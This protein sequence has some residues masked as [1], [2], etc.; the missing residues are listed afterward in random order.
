LLYPRDLLMGSYTYTN[1]SGAS[2]GV[3]SDGTK[4]NMVGAF[5]FNAWEL[6][7]SSQRQYT[8]FVILRK[9]I[10]GRAN[11]YGDGSG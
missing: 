6:T 2:L 9:A 1:E 4:N 7:D 10:S 8:S 5:R 3:L 11:G